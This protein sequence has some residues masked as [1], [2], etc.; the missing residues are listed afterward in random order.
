MKSPSGAPTAGKI[1]AV[2]VSIRCSLDII[3]KL[4]MAVTAE[5]NISVVCI[6][7]NMNPEPGNL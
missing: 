3:I 5:L 1:T 2:Y 4:G 6:T 7:V